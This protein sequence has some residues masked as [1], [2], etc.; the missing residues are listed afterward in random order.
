MNAT[1]PSSR[2]PSSARAFSYPEPPANNDSNALNK[3]SP[4]DRAASARDTNDR[5]LP[6]FSATGPIPFAQPTEAKNMDQGALAT[7]VHE[8][9]Y[10]DA[11]AVAGS[12]DVWEVPEVP[13]K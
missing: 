10:G 3:P 2:P 9:S 12:A 4:P 8:Q 1:P 13:K 11:N 5:P 7:A 6:V